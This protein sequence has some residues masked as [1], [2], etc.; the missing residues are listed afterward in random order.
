LEGSRKRNRRKS[1]EGVGLDVGRAGKKKVGIK[2]GGRGSRVASDTALKRRRRCGKQG[3]MGEDYCKKAGRELPE[4]VLC[5][6]SQATMGESSSRKRGSKPR[7]PI[8]PIE[9][10]ALDGSGKEMFGFSVGEGE[11]E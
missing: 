1:K 9:P 6:S 8:F 7:R 4:K 10:Y 3:P 11:R 5:S 2:R